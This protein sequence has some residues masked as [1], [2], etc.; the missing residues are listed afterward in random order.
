MKYRALMA[1]IVA[2]AV[3]LLAGSALGAGPTP[4]SGSQSGTLSLSNSP[5]LVTADI[6]VPQGQTL[7]IEPGVTLQFT[8][9]DI[10]MYVD[11]T[12]I[13][14]G[15]GGSPILFT[16]DKVTKQPGQWKG[17]DVRQY[18][19]SNT[20]LENCS[21]EYA[22]S[23]A[24][25][26]LGNI[27]FDSAPPILVT[28]CT[29]RNAAGN[30]MT[31]YNSD[32]RVLGC[33]FA[34]NT[35]FALVMRVDSLPTLRN[36]SAS[37]NGKNAIGVFGGGIARSGTWTRDN[38]PY[39]VYDDVYVQNTLTIEP[40]VTIQFQDPGNGWLV[41][42]TL[43][44][45]G[46]PVNP[47]LF[48]SDEA[49]KQ[50]GQW[51]G[52][53][54]RQ[55][56]TSNTVFENCTIEYAGSAAG[57]FLG[58]MLFDSAPPI[59]VTNCT[60]GNA[61]GNG[62]TLFNSDPRVVGCTF[63]NNTN[64]A[65]AMRA[66]CLPTL[67][68]NAASGSGKNA[69]GVFGLNV[70]RTGTWTRDNLP[71]TVY[72]D[73]YVNQSVTLTIEPGVTIQFQD[74]GNG[75]HVD[76][77]LIARG[78]P[79][80][81]ILFT[82]DE[83][84][85]QPGQWKGL[86][87]RQYGTSNTVLEYCTIEYAGST[88]GGNFYG[89]VLF[90]SAP[91]VLITNCTVRSA[92][93]NGM[94]LFNS[95]PRVVGC[96][97]SNNTNFA[98]AMRADCLPTLRSNAASG[99]GRNAIGVFGFNVSRT[100]TWTRDNIPYTAYDDVYV[101]QTVTLTIE[102]GVTI[103]F[104]DLTTGWY[105][106]GTLIAQGTPTKPI[107]FTSD[108]AVKQPGQ[109][110]GINVRQYGTANTVFE[111]CVIEDAGSVAGGFNANIRLDSAPA[112]L[113]TSCTIRDSAT[114]GIYCSVSSPRIAT[115]RVLNN[116]RDGIR[117]ESASSPVVTNSAISSNFVFGVNNLD[118]SKIIKAEGNY[119]GHPSGPFDNSNADGLGLTN[120]S[121]LGDKVS[122]YVDWSPFLTSDP[123]AAGQGPDIDVNPLSLNFGNVTP[124]QSS[125]LTLT[126]SNA[127]GS[128]LTVNSLVTN[129]PAYSVISPATPFNVSSNAQQ[130]VTL[131]FTPPAVGTQNG[132]LS[133]ASNDPDEPSVVVSLVGGGADTNCPNLPPGLVAWWRAEG[134][135][136][137]SQGTN[138]GGLSNG[139]TF[140]SGEVGL[141]FNF[142]G[143]NQYV[144]TPLDVQPSAMPSTT[145]EAWVYPTRLN[146]GRQQILSDDDGGYD[147]SVMIENAN[148]GIFTGGGVWEPAGATS[149]QWQ[150]I[151]VV[152]TPSNI[153]FYKNGVRFSYGSMPLF[154]GSSA[155]L[156]IA[157]NPGFGEHFQGR[158]DEVSVYNRALASNEIAAIFNAGSAGKCGFTPTN[159]PDIDVSPL[160][161]NFT[162]VLIGQSSNL[163][164]AI[165]NVGSNTLTVTSITTNNA[166]FSVASPVTPFNIPG[167]NGQ[168]ITV[169]FLPTATGTQNGQ[170][171][172][173]SNDPD[174]GTVNVAVSGNGVKANPVITWA[175]PASIVFGT[176]LSASQLN[177][178]SSVPGAFTYSPPAGT[179][180][181]AGNAQTL[182]ATFVPTDT[183]TYNT[184][185]ASVLINV[186]L[187]PLTITANNV[188]VPQGTAFPA[189]TA[190]FSGFVNGDTVAS[191]DSPLSLTT[192][193]N[194]GSAPGT[195]PI[196]ASG[197]AD[198]NY[199]ITFV[200][201]TLTIT[202]AGLTGLDITPAT[203]FLAPSQTQ[204]LRATG[205]FSDGTSQDVT[206]LTA[207][208][209]DASAVAT[210]NSTGLVSAVALGN[211]NV[212]ASLSNV[213]A[214]TRV[215]VTAAA[216]GTSFTNPSPILVSNGPAATYPSTILVSGLGGT[217]A[218]V[219]VTLSNVNHT[220][221]DDLDLLLVS[222]TGKKAVIMSDCGSSFDV[223]NLA[224]VLSDAAPAPLPDNS[225]LAA[226]IYR[227]ANYDQASDVF[228]AP[229]PAG[230]YG[231]TL[232]EFIGSA[233]NGAWSLF[234]VDDSLP[235][236]GSIAGGWTLNIVT[237]TNAS[238]TITGPNN[239]T[240]S[241]NTPTLP[242][243]FTVGDMETAV[244][245]LVVTVS[246]SNT[247][248]VPAANIALGGSGVSRTVTVTP[249][250]N[251]AGSAVITITVADA[252]GATASVSFTVT[253]T[254]G[255][256]TSTFSNADP[257]NIPTAVP[258][259][260]M[261]PKPAVPYPST[262]TVSGMQGAVTR[263]VVT[264]HRLS[265]TWPDDLD[266]LLV[267]PGGRKVFF[268]SDAGSHRAINNVTL[269]FDDAAPNFL[270]NA[271]QIFSG[272]Y[273]PTNYLSAPD[274][275][276]APA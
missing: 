128:V 131:R 243:P 151:A 64:F 52:I 231:A 147:R 232:A 226:G 264:L 71:Y 201:G 113:L 126:I 129:N 188:S 174:E 57:G 23:A 256:T 63:S 257:I 258:A 152:F 177:A 12:L 114:D 127:G 134:N 132:T 27:L 146:Y 83:A 137:D 109:W 59:L 227:P 179:V 245:Q 19:T 30:G 72:E 69:I 37:A 172:I 155:P 94:T 112:I 270:P 175:N 185:M 275:F 43:I 123:T 173:I 158:I 143:T 130:T 216:T 268:M 31:L 272:T 50:P 140:V 53:D 260:P 142:D 181:N 237:V 34:N 200:N 229:A 62:M 85:K 263:V 124:G 47:I 32:P 197:A 150:H 45:R 70:S 190:S 98:L 230:P 96:T 86:D 228:A 107:L 202:G 248:L 222:P 217:V 205:T 20:V 121:G 21:I 55:Y 159:A 215:I 198:A 156:R 250:A 78:T 138:N 274:S 82:S 67:R 139:V 252:L 262:I 51:K 14:H 254:G 242:L 84:V 35:N 25:G 224:L 29:I 141:A 160:S 16:S 234:V 73:V 116:G 157:R 214:S 103:Q 186:S 125:N 26:F 213:T 48:T 24:G 249:A 182:F 81:P 3:S 178:T 220:W 207:W 251:Q 184:V 180:L 106:D 168:T 33:T 148:F 58:N 246:S 210:I 199:N 244:T 15:T 65:L 80:S 166:R 165:N 89:N 22:G 266:V 102:P 104:Q 218:R 41:D 100:G 239:V 136:F 11:G 75:W 5:Y 247:R 211:A 221:P 61:A 39:T 66:D 95:D 120:S 267:G 206:L 111:N 77:T 87:V 276:P 28:N 90:D 196:V 4:I 10:G 189:L 17:I 241:L 119:W 8:N 170:V 6:S 253:V 255:G 115:C 91:P 36:N 133:I 118:T 167:L 236:S 149:N 101:N 191:L 99:S 193:G 60:I 265:H 273:R 240:N 212:T 219:T 97:F 49:V 162:N 225:A 194:A 195:Y 233:P 183:N 1:S 44:A 223:T 74:P 68:S 122:E 176:A 42:G 238:P 13:A 79:A 153:E 93:G 203:P 117:T 161:L 259:G 18:G 204:P 169:T 164:V 108:D 235:D 2:C 92:A 208:S 9:V 88:A 154:G 209:S 46:T 145:W 144:A 171:S 110:K 163:T 56:G 76:G 7:T 105:I 40:G 135:A 38:I 269:R 54:V 192:T 261:P 187:S 271:K